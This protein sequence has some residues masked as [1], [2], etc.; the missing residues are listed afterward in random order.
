MLVSPLLSLIAL[1][2][3]YKGD[4]IQHAKG[5]IVFNKVPLKND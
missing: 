2:D 4:S 1:N 3:L 5:I